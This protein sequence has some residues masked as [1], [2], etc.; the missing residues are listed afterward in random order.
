MAQGRL[1]RVLVV[2]DSIVMRSLLRMVLGTDPRITV[3]GSAT[4]G[5]SALRAMDQLH[6]DLVLMDIEMPGLD[7]LS[8]LRR[9]RIL[10]RRVPVIMCSTLTRR[11]ASVTIEALALGASDYVTKPSNVSSRE[12]AIRQLAEQLVPKVLAL[13]ASVI[14]EPRIVQTRSAA[15]A[16]LAP[17]APIASSTPTLPL[18]QGGFAEAKVVVLGISTG[19]PA[20][21]DQLMPV[22]PADFPLPILMVQHMPQLFTRLLA[23]RLDQ[24]TKLKVGEAVEGEPV[25]AGHVYIAPGDRHMEVVAAPMNRPPTLRITQGEP[26]NHCRPSVDVLFRTAVNAYG[27]TVLGVIM[28]GMGSDGLVGCKMIRK[29]GGTVLAQNQETSAVWGM[30]GCVVRDGV[31]DRVLPL[32]EIAA[33]IVRFATN[34]EC[35]VR[36]PSHT[37]QGST[38]PRELAG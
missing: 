7:G 19:G 38:A 1:I 8:T 10:N 4:D 25:L 26:E 33:T 36:E 28:T 17:F 30:P 9:M 22:F 34:R 21:L 16:P 27:R 24:R 35:F 11:G 6:P 13:T 31:A 18:R 14:E 37:E 29:A 20:A 3:V 15:F 2:D 32:N 12:E 23:E 5:E